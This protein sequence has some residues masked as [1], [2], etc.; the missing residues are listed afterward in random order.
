V[1][2]EDCQR[3]P[4]VKHAPKTAQ[5]TCNSTEGNPERKEEAYPNA[6]TNPTFTS[7]EHKLLEGVIRDQARVSVRIKLDQIAEALHLTARHPKEI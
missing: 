2:P 3:R 5:F 7:F 1:P 6:V 4:S